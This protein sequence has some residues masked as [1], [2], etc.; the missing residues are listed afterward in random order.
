MRFATEKY[1]ND[2]AQLTKKFIHLTNFSVNK[3]SS[4]F[5]KNVDN[6]G[7]GPASAGHQAAAAN[8][9][10]SG[11]EDGDQSSKWDFKMLKRAFQKQGSNYDMAMAQTKDIIIKT[12]ISVEPHIV[13]NLQKNPTNRVNCFEIYGFDV[14]IDANMKPWVLEVNVLP[15]LSS[16]SPFD[17]RI[18]TMLVCDALTCVGL[19]GY[20]KTKFHAQTTDVLGLAPFSPSMNPQELRER[21]LTGNEKLSKDELEM[22]MDLD[23]EYL[24]RGQFERIYPLAPNVNHYEQFFESKRYQ[25][26]LLQAYLACDNKTRDKL[27]SPK[28][29]RQYH[30]EV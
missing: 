19:R 26:Q 1:S 3:K 30:S 27:L 20:D 16:S 9:E 29:K 21:R 6:R 24:R 12:L 10:D 17:K 18:K 28:H 22:I 23:E 14:M 8:G 25:N 11:G 5:V 7:R 2:P 15:S 13:A 4:K